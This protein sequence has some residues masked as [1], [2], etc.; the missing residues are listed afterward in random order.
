MAIYNNCFT[1]LNILAYTATHLCIFHCYASA[2]LNS[3][4]AS[5]TGKSHGY[6]LEL[7][8]KEINNLKNM[9]GIAIL[10][11]SALAL[12]ILACTGA[13]VSLS[14]SGGGIWKYHDIIHVMEQ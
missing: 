10:V 5:I 12:I 6:Y 9:G 4:A 2:A 8:R 1:P 7:K 13:A 11:F 14:N 3:L